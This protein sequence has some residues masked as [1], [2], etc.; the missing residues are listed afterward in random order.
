MSTTSEL[1]QSIQLE[2]LQSIAE[3]L[4]EI[5]AAPVYAV[6][7]GGHQKRSYFAFFVPRIDLIANLIAMAARTRRAARACF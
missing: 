6:V 3:L 5:A 4:C 1:L 2:V 7:H